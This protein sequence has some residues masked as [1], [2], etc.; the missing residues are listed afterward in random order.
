MHCNEN[1]IKDFQQ[2]Y[3]YT[4]PA[5]HLYRR[6]D[7]MYVR[8]DITLGIFRTLEL[9]EEATSKYI[10]HLM[11]TCC[12]PIQKQWTKECINGY[13][14][15]EELNGGEIEN[16]HEIFHCV[17]KKDGNVRRIRSVVRDFRDTF[18]CKDGPLAMVNS[19]I[20]KD[21]SHPTEL[22]WIYEAIKSDT[23][24]F[25]NTRCVSLDMQSYDDA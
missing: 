3:V 12:E 4:M 6:S 16:D 10:A 22:H 17:F 1:V 25:Q 15:I 18:V 14:F 11:D 24:R 23:L 21:E 8:H 7:G 9:A 19:L 13:I 5:F 2:S 20:D